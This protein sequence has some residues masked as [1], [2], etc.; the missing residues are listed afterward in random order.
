M[1]DAPEQITFDSLMFPGRRVLYV[2]EV[3]ERWGVSDQHVIDLCEEGA[4][5][6]AFNIGGAGRKF[7]RIPIEGYEWFLKHRAGRQQSGHRGEIA[8]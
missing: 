4:I 5:P 7:W 3:A 6:G 1:L 8:S 2:N